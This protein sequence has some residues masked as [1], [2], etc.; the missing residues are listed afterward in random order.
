MNSLL[1]NPL[2]LNKKKDIS[3]SELVTIISYPHKLSKTEYYTRLNEMYSLGVNSI[4][5]EGHTKIGRICIVGKGSVSLVLKVK[6]K[7]N[8]NNICALKIRRT[9]ANRKTMKRE[10]YLHKIANSAGIGPCLLEFSKNFILMEFVYGLSIIDWFRQKNICREQVQNVIVNILEQCYT[11]DRANLD[12]GE[13]SHI[14]HH[15]VVSKQCACTIIDFESSSIQ[16]KTC[17]VTAAAQSLFLSGWISKRVNELLCISE[18]EKLIQILR[19]YKR[20]QT[21]S[22]FNSILDIFR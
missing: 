19:S 5:L 14:D 10:A 9:D 16:R 7:N 22:N 6:A 11:L 3:S 4:L 15:V 20:D 13:L 18:R 21:R 2:F 12:H 1:P 8:N 17:N